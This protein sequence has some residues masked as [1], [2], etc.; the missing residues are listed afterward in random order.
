MLIKKKHVFAI[1]QYY[2]FI[3]DLIYS[4]TLSDKYSLDKCDTSF[5]RWRY[6]SLKKNIFADKALVQY[7]TYK[8]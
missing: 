5:A 1:L 2:T 4:Y 7:V 3:V 8:I 6:F